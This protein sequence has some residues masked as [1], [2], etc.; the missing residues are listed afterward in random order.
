MQFGQLVGNAAVKRRLSSM[1]DAGHFPH[2]LLLEGEEGSGRRTLARLVARAA[3]CRGE[4]E[5]PCG[6]CS[7]C[8]K[9]EHPDVTVFDVQGKEKVVDAIRELRQEAFLLPNEAPHRVF[10]LENA[11]LLNPPAQNALLKILEEPPRH[12]LFILVCENRTQLLETIRSR[13]TLFTMQPVEWEE[14]APVLQSRLPS[15]PI[16]E[17]QRAHS[18]FGGRIGRVLDGV[19]DGA[20]RQVV[21]LTPSFA[22]ALVAPEELPLIRLTARL[23]KDKDLTAALLRSLTLVLRDALACRY[24]TPGRL[25]TAPEAASVLAQKLTGARLMHLLDTVEGLQQDLTRNMNNTLLLTRLSSRLRG[26]AGY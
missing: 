2:A 4:G 11:Q 10:I 24:G 17:L 9:A 13:C 26:A 1:V 12:V 20:F 3:T 16:E 21:E 19:R 6:S 25:S 22:Q 14:A 23:E 5:R 8:I 7:G 15:I 18:L